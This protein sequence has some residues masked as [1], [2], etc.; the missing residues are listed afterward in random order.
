VDREVVVHGYSLYALRTWSVVVDIR[1]HYTD[2]SFT[3]Y[4]SRT[5]WSHTIVTQTGKPNEH[6]CGLSTIHV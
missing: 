5:H 6:V 1:I 3:R 2:T 4:L